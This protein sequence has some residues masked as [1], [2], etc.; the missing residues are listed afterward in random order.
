MSDRLAKAARL[1]ATA[2]RAIDDPSAFVEFAFTDSH[3]RLLRQAAVHRELQAFLTE[4]PRALIELPR[5][6]G[7]SFQV[8][9]R[10]LWE[11]V[12]IAF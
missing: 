12:S 7:K 1:L 4:H 11:L 8:C 6:H 10:V 9:C 3:G 5:D 2:R